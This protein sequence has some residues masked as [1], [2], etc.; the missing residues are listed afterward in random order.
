MSIQTEMRV[1]IPPLP[2]LVI[3]AA[4]CL[5]TFVS[6]VVVLLA[7]SVVVDGSPAA[8]EHFSGFANSSGHYMKMFGRSDPMQP[9]TPTP[10][11]MQ[12]PPPAPM[13]PPPPTPMQPPPLNPKLSIEGKWGKVTIYQDDLVGRWE[14][15]RPEFKIEPTGA[16][17]RYTFSFPDDRVYNDVVA[18]GTPPIASMLDFGAGNV[19]AR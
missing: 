8:D 16:L 12:S 10:T 4:A 19:W 2:R 15:L 13:Q 14:S 11:P 9:P 17:N 5:A 3:V 1:A 7:A 6:G 18:S